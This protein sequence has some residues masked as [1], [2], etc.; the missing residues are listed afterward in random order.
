MLITDLFVGSVAI[1]LGSLVVAAAI[2]N[3]QWYYELHKARLVEGFCGRKGARLFFAVLGLGL[4]LLGGAIAGGMN[5]G[6]GNPRPNQRNEDSRRRYRNTH[7]ESGERGRLQQS[8]F[9]SLLSTL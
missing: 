6:N 2:F 9:Y 8:T 3:W 4:I 5:S 1:I 7:A